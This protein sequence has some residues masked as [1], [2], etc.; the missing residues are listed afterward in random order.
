MLLGSTT[1]HLQH[2][3]FLLLSLCMLTASSLAGIYRRSFGTVGDVLYILLSS[4]WLSRHV[5]FRY[6]YTTNTTSTKSRNFYGV[7]VHWITKISVAGQYF[8]APDFN[9]VNRGLGISQVDDVLNPSNQISFPNVTFAVSLLRLYVMD[10]LLRLVGRSSFPLD[11]NG[12]F[13]N[14]KSHQVFQKISQSIPPIQMM[15][16]IFSFGFCLYF[17]QGKGGILEVI[18]FSMSLSLGESEPSEILSKG[19]YEPMLPASWIRTCLYMSF[20]PT[21]LS[22]LFYGRIF[23]PIPDL[24][25]GTN[26]LKS[27][28]NEA[29]RVAT[30]RAY[31][32]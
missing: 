29:K 7:V 32:S 3:F 30:V 22:I 6:L 12:S 11:F 20:G 10:P 4:G 14:L 2:E 15:V 25:A 26:V 5:F 9:V 24:V 16:A 17:F 23:F 28:R 27:I 31:I 19:T 13:Q 1:I 21:I 8:D 18:R